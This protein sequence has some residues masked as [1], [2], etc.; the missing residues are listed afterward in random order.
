M[1]TKTR[2]YIFGFL[3]L[4]F[5]GETVNAQWATSGNDVYYNSGKVGIGTSNPDEKL[6]V[7]GNIKYSGF[8]YDS[9]L[10]KKVT[11]FVSDKQTHYLIL[12]KSSDIATRVLGRFLGI[13]S[14]GSSNPVSLNML[15][16]AGR[17]TGTAHDVNIQYS[18]V[19]GGTHKYRIS[20]VTLD[21]GGEN[22]VAIKIDPG[23][24]STILTAG[25]FDGV[26]H[27]ADLFVLPSDSV[28][29]VATY[30]PTQNRKKTAMLSPVF[31]DGNLGVGIEDPSNALEVNGTIRTKE[32]IVEA[33]GWPD[34][35]FS[36]S[37]NL[38]SL[39]EVEKFIQTNKHLPGVPSQKE[40]TE[41]GQSLG[42]TQQILL[43]KI[44]ELTLYMID[45][46]KEN[47]SLKE[48]VNELNKNI[49]T[50]KN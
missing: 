7:A 17:G 26:L 22:Y 12:F 15:I 3:V 27:K 24:T 2:I 18:S 41:K 23:S 32:V 45:L 50:N 16:E 25:Y 9:F 28:A 44:E 36:G 11:G 37:Y 5:T 6:E 49:K 40:V 46:K 13:R 4:L 47:D 43:K 48:Q 33:T 34:Y 14:H 20:S 30:S 8:G 10:R 35:V 42:E 38:P 29:N 31:I 21:Y 1:K 39:I 19:S